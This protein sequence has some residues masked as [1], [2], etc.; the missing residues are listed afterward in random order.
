LSNN[1]TTSRDGR[2]KIGLGTQD[3]YEMI[4]LIQ[5]LTIKS[6]RLEELK[7]KSASKLI[8]VKLTS[9]KQMEALSGAK[10]VME[11]STLD[12]TWARGVADNLGPKLVDLVFWVTEIKKSGFVG[13]D[14]PTNWLESI[15][16][17]IDI[18]GQ[19]D[20]SNCVHKRPTWMHLKACSSSH[21][22]IIVGSIISL[23]FPRWYDLHAWIFIKYKQ[24]EEDKCQFCFMVN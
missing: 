5:T 9:R 11:A 16:L 7:M 3:Y 14:K 4:R 20:E 15:K 21:V 8:K 12:R 10:L 24:D 13:V 2:D 18:G 19:S 1:R 23:I 17:V 6:H 22:W